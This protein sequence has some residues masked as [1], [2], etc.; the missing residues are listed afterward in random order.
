M[1]PERQNDPP[2]TEGKLEFDE[3]GVRLMFLANEGDLEGIN[4]VLDSGIDVNFKDI[5]SRTPLHVASCQG[6]PGVVQLL[7]ERGAEVDPKDR[8]GS[9]VSIIFH[10]LVLCKIHAF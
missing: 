6:F 4:E 10:F 5:D 9:T 8:W 7:L 1:A 2:K 3:E